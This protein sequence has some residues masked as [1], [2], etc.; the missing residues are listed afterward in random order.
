MNNKELT[1]IIKK[2]TDDIKVPAYATEN[3]SGLDVRAYLPKDKD[4]NL[5]GAVRMFNPNTKELEIHIHPGGRALIP[6]GLKAEIPVGFEL[7]VRPRSG[8]ALKQGITVLNAPGTVDSDYRG[9]IGV[10]LFNSSNQIFIVHQGDRIAQL[11]FSK[12]EQ[13]NIIEGEVSE[14]KRGEDGFSSTGIK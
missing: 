11:V 4:Y 7:Q 2:E 6:T 9:D 12:I 8:L 5:F 3:S 13:A 1:L 14:T 10:I